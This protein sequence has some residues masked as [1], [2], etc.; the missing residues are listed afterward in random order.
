MKFLCLTKCSLSDIKPASSFREKRTISTTRGEKKK[1]QPTVSEICQ[2]SLLLTCPLARTN[3][4]KKPEIEHHTSSVNSL[5]FHPKS[6]PR[7]QEEGMRN[8]STAL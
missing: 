3:Q 7:V 2:K 4:M 8:A 6:I 1:I 5:S